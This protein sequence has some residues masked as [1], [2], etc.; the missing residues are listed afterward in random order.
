MLRLWLVIMIM[1]VM[2]GQNEEPEKK[3][4]KM[5][6]TPRQLDKLRSSIEKPASSGGDRISFH[7]SGAL[8]TKWGLCGPPTMTAEDLLVRG[9]VELVRLDSL[10]DGSPDCHL[11][12]D[13]DEVFPAQLYHRLEQIFQTTTSRDD[14]TSSRGE[15]GETKLRSGGRLGGEE[16][17]VNGIS[18]SNSRVETSGER[19]PDE[20][21]CQCPPQPGPTAN[22]VLK[23]LQK[24]EEMIERLEGIGYT[25]GSITGGGMTIIGIMVTLIHRFLVKNNML[26]NRPA[27]ADGA[28]STTRNEDTGTGE[29]Q[30]PSA[31]VDRK[32]EKQPTLRKT[33]SA[34]FTRKYNMMMLKKRKK[35]KKT[36]SAGEEE[37]DDGNNNLLME[38]L[39]DHKTHID[40]P[41]INLFTH[42]PQPPIVN[43]DTFANR[44]EAPVP[45][46]LPGGLK[47]IPLTLSSSGSD[48]SSV[49]M[50]KEDEDFASQGQGEGAQGGRGPRGRG[51]GEQAK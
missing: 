4:I 38:E 49:I 32:K 31:Q 22:R 51:G 45:P 46:V 36:S 28:T 26:D 27:P 48:I 35:N 24:I 10:G 8:F 34:G 39:T 1:G 20:A 40:M 15:I 25:V 21:N 19:R 6:F 50:G 30:S 5:M 23:L 18:R 2:T 41:P 29:D 17:N 11:R 12:E 14:S 33:L 37:A 3:T 44:T 16:N 47:T 9:G 43:Q 7:S 13:W 42:Q